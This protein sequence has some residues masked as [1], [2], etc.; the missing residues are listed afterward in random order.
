MLRI[1]KLLAGTKFLL[2]VNSILYLGA[3]QADT[4]GQVANEREGFRGEY[5]YHSYVPEPTLCKVAYSDRHRNH[6]DVW[7]AKSTTPTPV[8]ICI[9]GGGW[10][11]GS[12]EQVGKYVHP[13]KLLDAGI[14]VVAINY[15][16]IKHC[17]ELNPPVQGPMT[18]SARAVQFVRSNAKDWNIDPTRIGLTGGSAGA[19]TSLW[20]A[21]H[22]DLAQPESEDPVAR[23]S[24]RVTCVAVI[25]AQTTLDPK[26]MKSWIPNSNYGGHAFGFGR[27]S[28][29]AFLAAR[30]SILPQIQEYSPY[31]QLSEGDPPTFLYYTT[32]PHE[33]LTGK[34]KPERDP[35]HSA[36]FGVH[37]K[38]QA[39]KL[40]V[41]CELVHPGANHPLHQNATEFFVALLN[42]E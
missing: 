40:G 31:A 30:D 3:F 23:E 27:D 26:Q 37:L 6:L 11:G 18:D 2:F 14:S 4:F 16:L 29:D 8:V 42:A 17:A 38:Q 13:Q 1:A 22:P 20:I 25:R 39:D 24:T 34:D 35:T 15:R 7:Q 41:H 32:R 28:F 10:N 19:C 21:Y 9:H 36:N 12:K 5:K 33:G